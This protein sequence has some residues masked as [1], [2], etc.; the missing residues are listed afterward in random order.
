MTVTP[1][2]PLEAIVELEETL[3]R[4]LEGWDRCPPRF[5]SEPPE[6]AWFDGDEVTRVVRV[7]RKLKHT[8]DR[9]AGTPF[10]PE[11]WQIVWVIAPVF[12]WK[13]ADGFRVARKLWLEIPRKNG[14]SS[15]ASRLA[16]FLLVADRQMGA[17]VYAA[18]TAESQARQV[19]DEAKLVVQKAPI[20]KGKVEVLASVMRVPR[21]AGI[22]RVLSKVGDTAHGLNVSGAVVDEVH[23][24]KN[25][26]L[27]EAIDT[28]TLARQ[29]PLIV[30]IT[31]AGDDDD[32][33]V[34]AK[35]HTYAVKVADEKVSDPSLWVVV[36]A[37]DPKADPL[38][39]ETF[40]S[41]NPNYPISPTKRAYE[42]AVRV[43]REIPS[44]LASYKRLH[45]NI[46]G[47]TGDQAWDGADAWSTGLQ[48]VTPDKVKG[49]PV[50][51]GL[52]S[53][54][55]SD[56]TAVAVVARNPEKPGWW[57][58]WHW[59]CPKDSLEL[60]DR[61]TEGMASVWAGENRLD[62]TE[63]NVIDVAR[64]T[65]VIRSIAKTYDM[66]EMAFDPNGAVG[67]VS[68]IVEEFDDRIVPI[69][70]TNPASALLDWERLLR[71]GEFFHGGDPI[72]T[73]QVAHLRVKESAAKIVKID[74]KASTENVLGL[75]AAEL[76]LR[77]ALIA[78]EPAPSV[79]ESRG[80]RSI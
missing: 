14:K 38:D 41:A 40:A 77:R 30:Y 49:K 66:R 5:V 72:A 19:F 12:G 57:C 50:W 58:W 74:R 20:L 11:P 70:S 21:T 32:T 45:L 23:L 43:A 2:I 13:D 7:L 4:S 33:T 48:S 56:L 53:S 59:F 55:A 80:M 15:L 67:I 27:I 54:S 39:E 52:V 46:R 63:G 18:A 76:A 25:K 3:G 29:Q 10:E 44:E 75:A 22:F 69:Y 65:E 26:A 31:T 35:K 51:L 71:A 60:L 68:P 78:T 64:H 16:V 17:E 47:T 79:Y 8:K 36:F 61:R 28:G 6:D 42:D 34:Y 37:A 1:P 73:W 62:L 24:H 9:W